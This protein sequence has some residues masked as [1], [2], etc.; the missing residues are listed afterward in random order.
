M[1]EVVLS[2]DGKLRLSSHD[3]AQGEAAF[4]TRGAGKSWGGGRILFW[5]PKFVER[6]E[7]DRT[8]RQIRAS[9]HQTNKA[10]GGD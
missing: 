10:G 1:S 6:P 4:A 2:V 8:P 5:L 9:H 3:I 7:G